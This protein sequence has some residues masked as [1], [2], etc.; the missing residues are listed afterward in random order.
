MEASYFNHVAEFKRLKAR[1]QFMQALSSLDAAIESCPCDEA[2]PTLAAWRDEMLPLTKP[3]TFL[4]RVLGGV[5][6]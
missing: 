6:V 2:L 3:Q 4:A 5:R 1:R